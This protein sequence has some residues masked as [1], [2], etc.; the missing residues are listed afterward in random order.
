VKSDKTLNSQESL[1]E[2]KQVNSLPRSPEK[3]PKIAPKCSTPRR[4]SPPIFEN[5][6]LT[7]RHP[8]TVLRN[9]TCLVPKF[10]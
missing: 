6:A 2:M 8:L 1:G 10:C 7:Y 4:E 3:A 5:P 9:L